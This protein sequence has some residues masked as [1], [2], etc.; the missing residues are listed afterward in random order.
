MKYLLNVV[1]TY[2]VDTVDEALAM[3]DE[4]AAASEYELQSFQYTT[5]FN[6]KT[7]EEYQV[8]KAK[9]IINSEKEPTCGVK[10]TY[11]Y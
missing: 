3:R 5:K 6:K 10:V 9:K 7:E 11:E 1:E 4:M 2:R 8:V